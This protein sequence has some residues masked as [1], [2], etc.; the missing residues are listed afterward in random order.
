[1]LVRKLEA[2]DWKLE[3]DGKIEETEL[4]SHQASSF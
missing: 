1:M 2:R 3:G 4:I